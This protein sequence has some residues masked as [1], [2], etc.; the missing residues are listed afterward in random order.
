MSFPCTISGKLREP[1][2]KDVLVIA[3]RGNT[4]PEAVSRYLPRMAK[5]FAENS[6][7]AIE[8]AIALGVDAVEVDV[9]HTRDG[10]LVLMHDETLA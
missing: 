5:G 1:A 3:H 7:E 4:G 9:R 6:L 10:R 2:C 8:A